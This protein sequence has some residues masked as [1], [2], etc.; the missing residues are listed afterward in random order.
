MSGIPTPLAYDPVDRAIY[1]LDEECVRPLIATVNSAHNPEQALA[2]GEAIV[3]AVN[4]HD[5][6]VTALE[7]L[8]ARF[9][10]VLASTGRDADAA[11]E[12]APQS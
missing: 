2:H 9:R 12:Q 6:L 4:A 1:H 7:N 5:A 3:R 10:L 11:C 8:R